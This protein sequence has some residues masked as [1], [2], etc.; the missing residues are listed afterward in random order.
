[1]L[2]SGN[3]LG[4]ELGIEIGRVVV[5]PCRHPGKATDHFE[6]RQD[7]RAGKA[8]DVLILLGRNH[9]QLGKVARRLHG[10]RAGCRQIGY[11]DGKAHTGSKR[12]TLLDFHKYCKASWTIICTMYAS[13]SSPSDFPPAN[14]FLHILDDMGSFMGDEPGNLFFGS[15]FTDPSAS[16]KLA[17]NRL[18]A[19]KM[20]QGCMCPATRENRL[21]PLN[22]EPLQF[23]VENAL[24]EAQ[25]E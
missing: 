25:P 5:R 18:A 23:L 8:A 1:L 17:V 19:D 21:F 7:K 11:V 10:I 3:H 13:A 4:E 15:P 16:N 12:R 14:V 2:A 9:R 24:V 6:G 22:P 20:V